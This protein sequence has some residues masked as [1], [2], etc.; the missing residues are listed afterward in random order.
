ML[1]PSE[2][3]LNNSSKAVRSIPVYLRLDLIGLKGERR[4]KIV[5]NHC[6]KRSVQTMM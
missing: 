2:I 6:P 1:S 4:T 3:L 5:G